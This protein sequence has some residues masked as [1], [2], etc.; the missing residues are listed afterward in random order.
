MIP[1][2]NKIFLIQEAKI[3]ADKILFLAERKRKK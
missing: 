3:K 2:V 1:G